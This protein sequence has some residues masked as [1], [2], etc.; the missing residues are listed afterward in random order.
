LLIYGLLRLE[1]EVTIGRAALIIG[2]VLLTQYC[3]SRVWELPVFDPRSALISGL[4]LCLMLRTNSAWL[5]VLAAVVSIASKFLVRVRGKHI[6]NPT[7]F[8]IVALLAATGEVWVSPGQWG[9]TV[10]LAFLMACLGGLVVNRAARSDV[11]FAFL[12]AWGLLVMGRSIWLGDPL[13]VPLHRLANGSLLLF[14]FF[15]I[16]DPKTTPDSRAG[17]IVFAALVALGAYYVQYKLFRTN[18]LLWSLAACSPL[19]PLI[20]RLIP[21]GRY[22]WL[23]IQSQGS[24]RMTS[25]KR[26]AS[27]LLLV[28]VAAHPAAAFCG[29]YVAKA[30]SRL[31]NRASQVVLVRDG[32]RTVMTMANDFKGELKEFAIVIP[33]PTSIQR[34]Q[35]NV[36]DKMIIDHL[37]AYSAPRL[38]EYFD[39]NPCRRR[40][41]EEP[42]SSVPMAS[43]R[44]SGAR[45]RARS[46]GV[47]IEAQYTVG[48]YDILILSATQSSGLETWLRENAYRVPQGAGP[49]LGSYIKQNM[50]FFVARVN[51]KEQAKLGFSYLRPI[52]V[53]YESPKFMLPIR[54]GMLNADGPQDL[55]LYTLTRKGRV[56][57][58]NYRT[59]KL[60]TGMELPTF[61]KAEFGRFYGAM[62]GEQVRRQ[63]MRT[64]FVEYAWDMAWCDPCAADPLS[65]DE[66]R[67][68]GVFWLDE[69][70]GQNVFLTR[71]HARYD[72][73]HFPDDLVLQQTAD[74]EN[75]Q[76]RYVL[77]HPWTGGE[78][79][80]AAEQYRLDLRQRNEREAQ[81]L[82]SLTGWEVE[83]IRKRMPGLTVE[84]P[85]DPKW[86][87]RLWK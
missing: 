11:T 64:V 65:N 67:K 19:V 86:W 77:R 21:G 33:V 54:L 38:V 53:A 27:I 18:G 3:C 68:L 51:L 59:V 17:R 83:S 6:F 66:L 9:N 24:I 69:G 75:F 55:Y 57:T 87:Q 85:R 31:F 35:I 79:C 44:M 78:Y 20:D 42:Q 76:G 8:G 30:D 22:D 32:D 23:H 2:S 84:S 39:E 5:A 45:D 7:N 73:A 72:N 29:F 80:S 41:S 1:F 82:A 34:D 52:Q 46:L 62:F 50:R 25:F 58:T 15:M 10:L 16:S 63:D 12:L 81:T 47:T 4:S 48:E 28:L 74:R 40:W 61:V 70:R 13:S 37:D 14:A 26:V 56:E 36:G 71:L 60:P 49:V 43:A